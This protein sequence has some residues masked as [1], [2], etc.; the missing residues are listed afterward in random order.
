MTSFSVRRFLGV[1]AIVFASYVPDVDARAGAGG[2]L[3][4]SPVTTT[5][6]LHAHPVVK[7]GL[8]YRRGVLTRPI[9]FPRGAKQGPL[10]WWVMRLVARITVRRAER[11]SLL[12]LTGYTNGRASVQVKVVVPPRG[13]PRRPIISEAYGLLDG[14][15][16][17][18]AMSPIVTVDMRNYLQYRGV[19]SGRTHFS[20]RLEEYGGHV[21]RAGVLSTR[22]G[23]SSGHRAPARVAPTLDRAGMSIE[24]GL[25]TVPLSVA[26]H[27]GRTAVRVEPRVSFDHAAL[28]LIE[29]APRR[30]PRLAPGANALVVA[31]FRILRGGHTVLRFGT[32]DAVGDGRAAFEMT[33]PVVDVSRPGG[34]SGYL[35]AAFGFIGGAAVLLFA[36]DRGNAERVG[37]R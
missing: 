34:L 36:R 6:A 23:I 22:T 24:E 31:R 18:T 8:V 33:L 5:T 10:R 1:C 4:I 17:R 32:T 30:L 35:L 26:N 16:R 37:A 28:R 14:L 19:R 7:P 2:S 20:L 13:E 15:V 12:Y 3:R 27:G 11:A 21:F 9:R 29:L 25:L